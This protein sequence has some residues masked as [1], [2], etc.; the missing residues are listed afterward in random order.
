MASIVAAA[1]GFGPV[2]TTVQKFQEHPAPLKLLPDDMPIE[3]R[4]VDQHGEPMSGVHVSISDVLSVL[5]RLDKMNAAGEDPD[6][7]IE[8]FYIVPGFAPG[9]SR[10]VVTDADGRFRMTGLGSDRTADLIIQ[11]GGAAWAVARVLT[12]PGEKI[13]RTVQNY[14]PQ[15]LT[16]YG[17][18]F[19]FVAA[20]AFEVNGI[21]TDDKTHAP[22][23]GVSVQSQRL[24]G[25]PTPWDVKGVLRTTTD[26]QGRY[27]LK[28]I[29]VGA[30]NQIIALPADDRPYFQQTEE[31]PGNIPPGGQTKADI[32]LHRGVWLTGKVTDQKTGMPVHAR[33]QFNP[34]KSNLHAAEI[35]ELAKLGGTMTSDWPRPFGSGSKHDGTY[36]IVATPGRSIIVVSFAEKAYRKG[37]GVD[38]L[39][40][41]RDQ[42]DTFFDFSPELVNA[43]KEI[44]IPEGGQNATLDFS[45]DPGATIKITT[46]DSDGNPLT[47]VTARW[48]AES[49][50]MG[51]Q[52][53]TGTTAEFE[54]TGLVPE[55][56][57]TLVFVHEQRKLGKVVVVTPQ[58]VQQGSMQVT[59]EP[60]CEISGRLLDRQG[61]PIADARVD[62]QTKTSEAVDLTATSTDAE[63]RFRCVVP[64]GC[65]YWFS[66][67]KE[68]PHETDF[69]EV[70]PPA[71]GTIDVGDVHVTGH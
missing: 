51:G 47:G 27:R 12:R 68:G 48:L 10:D 5:I 43:V 37:V 41:Q 49:R 30:G 25:H 65:N 52:P 8:K 2:S 64:P 11:G 18:K 21:V 6:F 34:F 24:S 62:P 66:F 3:G 14:L 44:D 39:H 15:T 32:E 19:E 45:L 9:V 57:R 35:P 16:T 36:K 55:G 7:D 70:E 60:L 71:G 46:T 29:P 56:N 31:L 23:A 42:T 4:I 61:K 38:Q 20:P 22:L 17:A 69:T 28:S 13:T 59:L 33:L 40:L 53:Q 50:M 58:D 26:A 63:G 1:E 67:A 54:A